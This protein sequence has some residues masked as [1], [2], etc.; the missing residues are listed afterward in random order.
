MMQQVLE[1]GR[2]QQQQ[3]AALITEMLPVSLQAATR[4][5]IQLISAELKECTLEL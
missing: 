3:A 4:L 1:L 2:P 5:R